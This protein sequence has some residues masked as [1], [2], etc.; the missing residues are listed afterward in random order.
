MKKLEEAE[1]VSRRKAAKRQHLREQGLDAAFA[2]TSRTAPVDSFS[3][4]CKTL[5]LA[6]AGVPMFAWIVGVSRSNARPLSSDS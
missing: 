4:V 3:L 2:H 1:V 5:C 6:H